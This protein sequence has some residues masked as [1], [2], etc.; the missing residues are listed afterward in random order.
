V[1]AGSSEHLTAPPLPGKDGAWGA[2]RAPEPTTVGLLRRRPSARTRRR[3]SEL[4]IGYALLAPAVILLLVFEVFPIFYGIYISACDWRL[5]CTSFLGAG[6]YLK[7]LQDPD[8]WHSL[9]VTATY[10]LICVPLQIGLG[11]FLAYLLF[12]K[13]HGKELFRVLFFLP[14]ITS[15]VA[16]A[17]IW[18][19]L[20]SPDNGLFNS[21]LHGVGLPTFRWLAEPTGIFQ[22]LAHF[23]GTSLPS[24]AQGPSLALVCLVI[25]T[26]WT[27]VGYDVTI[28][29]AG[30]GNIPA[31]LYDA[32][33]VDG[34]SGWHL[35]RHIT[36]PLL[37]PTTFFLLVFTVIGTFKA[38]N[39][40]WVMTQGGPLNATR[41]SSILIFNELYQDNKYGYAAA[42]SFILFSV[43]LLLTLAQNRLA[44]RRVVYD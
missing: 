14:Y 10:A 8:M 22:M 19:Y 26:T 5:S 15:T 44:G 29:L 7:A 6:N 9:L 43:I 12:Q 33:R 11:L 16:S 27:F 42:L 3:L 13:V 23:F 28:F 1:A 21:V 36:F 37:S 24:W 30:L 2:L 25:F 39:H 35:F 32:A 34:A 20:Y 40:I 18:S 41:T 4:G 38:F 17:A 31:E